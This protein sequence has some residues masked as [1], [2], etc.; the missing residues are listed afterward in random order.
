ME[1]VVALFIPILVSL[2]TLAM[3]VLVRRM[4][5]LEKM[6]MIEMGTDMSTMIKPRNRTGIAI[7]I[8]LMLIGIGLGILMGNVLE[9]QTNLNE[10]AG[11]FAMVLLFG[12]A[13]LF[14]GNMIAEK[15]LQKEEDRKRALE[16]R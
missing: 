15:S 10:E 6:K 3:I 5:H 7:K 14:V 9:T 8:A 11:Y 4:E 12:G 16:T 2:G 1:E 13:G